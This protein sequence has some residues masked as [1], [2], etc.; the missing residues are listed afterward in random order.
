MLNKVL[1]ADSG[2]G[3]SEEMLSYLLEM[4]ALQGASVTI[5]HVV[6]PQITA[7]S[8]SQKWEAGGKLLAQAIENL[9]L[10]PAK[11][12]TVLRQGDPKDVVYHISEE[13]A[14]DLVIMG[15]RGL[16]RIESI[17]ENSVSQYVF[18]L[19]S[20]SLLVVK[21]DVYVK[22]IKRLGV[23]SDGSSASQYCLDLAFFLLQDLPG[24]Q[25]T[26][27]SVDPKLKAGESLSAGEAAAY[28]TLSD[29][30]ARAK[31]QGIAYRCFVVGGKAGEQICRLSQENDLDLLLLGSPEQR[32]NVARTLPDFDR[33]F[34]SSVSD[35][36]RV[37]A[38][39]PVLLGRTGEE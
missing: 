14:P 9:K 33:L 25:L 17:L 19:A 6:P 5:L 36:V 16:K 30:V 1:L 15:S 22:R 35:Y 13:I 23:A 34:G 4:P 10:D 12:T 2:T 37:N 21:D 20:H 8:M 11:V 3:H 24:A 18:Q 28:P 32:P 26:L 27:M 29:A 38:E 7:Q 39:C 31:R